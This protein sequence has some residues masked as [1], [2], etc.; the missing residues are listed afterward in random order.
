MGKRYKNGLPPEEVCD[1]YSVDAFRLYEMYLGPIDTSLPWEGEAIVGLHRFLSHV[2]SLV[3][4]A[5]RAETPDDALDKLVHRTIDIVTRDL[6]TLR[7][8]TAIARVIELTNALR[9]A[10]AVHPSHLEALVLLIAPYAPHLAEETLHRLV[11]ERHAELG[12][13]INFAWPAFDPD[14]ARADLCTVVVQ[15]NGK[16]R[17]TL[18]VEREITGAAL[19]ASARAHEKV[20]PLLHGQQIR[21]VVTVVEP[22]PK[23]VNFV[24]A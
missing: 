21:R 13:V 5:P 12:S 10:P 1:E 8:N 9:K 22:V 24:L 6:E 16:K 23:L 19:E 18:D 20:A 11:P 2:W 15:V 14:R 7:F 17:G 4:R 3:G